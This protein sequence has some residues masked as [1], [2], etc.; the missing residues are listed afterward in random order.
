MIKESF[1][2]RTC[3]LHLHTYVSDGEMTPQDIISCAKEIG[4]KTISI[5]D[6]DAVGAYGNFGYDPVEMAAREGINL[7]P[8]I[9]LDSYYGDVEIHVLGYGID[10]QNQELNSYLAG[11]KSA[12][13]KRIEEQIEKVNRYHQ[14]ELIRREEIF[15]P[16]RD[17]LMNPHLVHVLLKQG[18]F[19]GYRE[20]ARWLAVHARSSVMLPNPSTAEMVRLIKGAGGS[21]FIA[22]PGYYIHE[23]GL[24]FDT[25]LQ[26]LLP[27]G[28][29]GVETEFPYYKTAP[30]FQTR[31]AERALIESLE[32][33]AA[34]YD[35]RTSRGS[36][37][38]RVDQLRAFNP[39]AS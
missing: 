16:H 31:E 3:D 15:L 7:I 26:E 33:A 6:H 17:T 2:T 18:L 21:A 27:E 28:L 10:L 30:A 23:G 37:A 11:V 14:K 39:P 9:E 29:D 25:V 12:R 38:H 20:A 22:H 8:G 13:K 36:D 34:R 5:T 24:D 4:L 1:C 19:S 32:Q 35:L